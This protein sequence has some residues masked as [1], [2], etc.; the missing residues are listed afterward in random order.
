LNGVDLVAVVGKVRAKQSP[1]RSGA[2]STALAHLRQRRSA[3]RHADE[4]IGA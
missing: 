3:F 2:N 1:L 4:R